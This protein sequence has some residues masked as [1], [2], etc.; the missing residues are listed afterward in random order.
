MLG[1]KLILTPC[2]LKDR[3]LSETVIWISM[4]LRNVWAQ[5]L[6]ST[7]SIESQEIKLDTVF[8]EISV[9]SHNFSAHPMF[10]PFYTKPQLR[11]LLRFFD[12][13]YPGI[14]NKAN[15]SVD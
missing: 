6:G 12:I 7:I 2:S 15:F 13:V 14:A 3:H 1:H 5:G 8:G 11:F 10:P 9:F 4:G